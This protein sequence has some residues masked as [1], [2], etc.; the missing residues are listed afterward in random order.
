MELLAVTLFNDLT[1]RHIYHVI[2][3]SNV[4]LDLKYQLSC[5]FGHFIKIYWVFSKLNTTTNWGSISK[6]IACHGVSTVHSLFMLKPDK[7][8]IFIFEAINISARSWNPIIV[9][10]F[11]MFSAEFCCDWWCR[12]K[13]LFSRK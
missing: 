2:I 13:I 3:L 8:F 5:M 12:L 10:I 11:K 4:C 9:E 7:D 1:G 6:F